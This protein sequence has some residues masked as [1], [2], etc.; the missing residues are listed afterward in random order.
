MNPIKHWPNNRLLGRRAML[1]RMPNHELA[2]INVFRALA[3]AWVL[4]AHCGIWGGWDVLPSPKIAVNLF[5]MISGVLMA[6]I[7]LDLTLAARQRRAFWVRRFF[8]IAP[9]YYV[10]LILAAVTAPLFLDGYKQLQLLNPAWRPSFVYD[11]S[12]I[13]FTLTTLLTHLTFIFGLHPRWSFSTFLPDWSLSLEVQFYLVLP[14]IA[15]LLRRVGWVRGAVALSIVTIVL[16]ALLRP[17][18]FFYE[19]SFLVLK[20]PYFLA[21]MLLHQ[22]LRTQQWQALIAATLLCAFEIDQGVNAALAGSGLLALMAF[23]GALV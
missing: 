14:F 9:A 10:S 20:L 16:T 1:P 7:T 15:L 12:R 21:G 18:V 22:W 13:E 23:F 11:P 4:V 5:M 19:P 8:R 6:S 17:R 3:A 2:F